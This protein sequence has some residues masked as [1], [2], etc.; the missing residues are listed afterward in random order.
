M[1][2][3]LIEDEEYSGYECDGH[4]VPHLVAANTEEEALSLFP[5]IEVWDT[6][7]QRRISRFLLPDISRRR[8]AFRLF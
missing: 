6:F 2:W 5:A 7:N 3:W 1:E 4:M 8:K